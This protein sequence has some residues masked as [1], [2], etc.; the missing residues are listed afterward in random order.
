ME[1]CFSRSQKRRGRDHPT[2][3]RQERLHQRRVGFGSSGVLLVD[4]RQ[5]ISVAPPKCASSRVSGS[6]KTTTSQ[7]EG[8]LRDS[9]FQHAITHKCH[10]LSVWPCTNITFSYSNGFKHFMRVL[11]T[12]QTNENDWQAAQLCSVLFMRTFTFF[13]NHYPSIW[14]TSPKPGLKFNK[15]GFLK[16]YD[17]L[18]TTGGLLG[19]AEHMLLPCSNTQKVILLRENTIILH[20]Y[21]IWANTVSCSH[22]NHLC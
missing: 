4:A 15:F 21:D 1:T 14:A 9:S 20:Y 8:F 22:D 7:S 5:R 16:A 11:M 2:S 3:P 17:L 12:R 10:Q 13:I 19:D 18:W 6:S